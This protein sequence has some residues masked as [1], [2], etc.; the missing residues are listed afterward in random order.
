MRPATFAGVPE[1]LYPKTRYQISTTQP[2]RDYRRGGR[3]PNPTGAAAATSPPPEM[4]V[5]AEITCPADS[6]LLSG[7]LETVPRAR[8]ELERQVPFEADLCPHVWVSGGDRSDV[9]SALDRDETV[10]DYALLESFESRS[11]YCVDWSAADSPLVREFAA[12]DVAVLVA[13]GAN[14]AWELKLRFRDA[15]ELSTFHTESREAGV[16]LTLDRLYDPREES[17]QSQL[18]PVQRETLL[19]AYE[20]GYFEIPRRT[21]LVELGDLL[22]ISDQSVSERLRRAQTNLMM[23]TIL[24][25][26]VG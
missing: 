19:L 16:D 14:E 3:R 17:V 22:D 6:F 4:T 8:A 13:E 26:G 9:E 25:D 18:T 2:E 7:T 23:S 15:A 10:A 21:T 12:R 20:E 24:S 1:H 5:I 11:L